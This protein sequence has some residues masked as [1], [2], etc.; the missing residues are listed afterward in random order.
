MGILT[1]QM[2]LGSCQFIEFLGQVVLTVSIYKY[3][4]D[5]AHKNILTWDVAAT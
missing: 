1:E 5:K 3:M 2:S 4:V